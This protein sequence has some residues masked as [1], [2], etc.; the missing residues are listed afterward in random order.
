M[1]KGD[2]CYGLSMEERIAIGRFY[3]KR[4]EGCE[5]DHIVPVSKGGRHELSNLQYL[6]PEENRKKSAKE[7]TEKMKIECFNASPF[8]PLPEGND[9]IDFS[10]KKR[11][12]GSKFKR[13]RT[14]VEK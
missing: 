5:V 7:L 8:T 14:L 6:T 13:M 10:S 2:P 4:P 12:K 3:R 9:E 1:K 11:N